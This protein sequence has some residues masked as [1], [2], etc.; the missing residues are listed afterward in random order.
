MTTTLTSPI[1]AAAVHFAIG[2]LLATGLCSPRRVEHLDT[3]GILPELILPAHRSVAPI[4]G[5]AHTMKVLHITVT[6]RSSSRWPLF[7][8]VGTALDGSML[9]VTELV[10]SNLLPDLEENQT[11]EITVAELEA[12]AGVA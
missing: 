3:P 1:P 12:L 8:I 10:K 2:G 9:M 7:H 11:R 6:S 4:L 5:Y